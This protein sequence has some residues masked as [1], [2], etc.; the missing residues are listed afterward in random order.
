MKKPRWSRWL[1]LPVVLIAFFLFNRNH[2]DETFRA[3]PLGAAQAAAGDVRYTKCVPLGERLEGG[4]YDPSVAYTL[5]GSVGWLAYSLVTGKHKPIGA[6]VHTHLARSTDAGAS[7]QFVKV[8]NPATDA[9]L[10]RPGQDPLPGVWRYEVPTLVCDAADPDPDGR[11][12]LFVHRY[13]WSPKQDRMVNYGWIALRT[14][15]DPAGKWSAEVPLFGAGKSPRAPYDKTLIDLNALAQPLKNTVAYSEPGALAHE[16]RLYLSMTA[17]QP[18]LSLKGIVVSH[19]IVLFASD[20]HARSWRFV[21]TL[22]T[23]GDAGSLGCDFF[24]GS[25]LAED[26]GR[27]FL[28]AAP[29]LNKKLETHYGTAA[30]EFDSLEKGRL[31]RSAK[32]AP[33]VAAYFAPQPSIFSGPGAGQGTYDAKN[34]AGGLLMP[35]FNLRTYPEVF[36]IFQTGRRILPHPEK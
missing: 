23:P 6:Y 28:L 21:A 2:A 7:W 19:T 9:V 35:Q 4:I 29:M 17:L 14:A 33:V 31:R 24:D 12:K 10:T 27:F 32:D 26:G 1:I 20:D 13:F 15:A 11:W 25:A 34:T 18:R 16:G 3:G 30:F 8:L 22:L 5:D 36:Q